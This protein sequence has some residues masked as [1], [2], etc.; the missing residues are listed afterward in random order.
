MT[1]SNKNNIPYL[2]KKERAFKLMVDGKPFISLAGEVHNSSSSSLKYMDEHVWERLVYFNCNTAVVPV[3]W[4]LIEPIEGQFDFTLVDGLI[5]GARRHNLKLVL[6]WFGMWKNSHSTYVPGWVKRDQTRFPR[7]QSSGG[8]KL[9]IV[10]CHS[11]EALQSDSNAF[12][13]L[14]KHIADVDHT[15]RTVIMMQVEN[16]V[17]FLGTDRDYSPHANAL[18]E[19]DVPDELIEYLKQHSNQLSPELKKQ[20]N[21]ELTVSSSWKEHFGKSAGVIF[22]SWHM[23]RFLDQVTAAGKAEYNLPMFVNVWL[24]QY[25]EQE[26]GQYPSGGPIQ[27]MID[28]WKAGGPHIDIIAPDIY[29]NE[30][31]EVCEVY[32]RPDNALFIPETRRDK[33]TAANVFYAVGEHNALGYTPF[34]IETM[35]NGIDPF[36]AGFLPPTHFMVMDSVGIGPLLS[37]SFELIHHMT[38]LISKYAGTG[39]M[40]GVLQDKAYPSAIRLGAYRLPIR[41]KNR[42]HSEDAP[43]GGL[44]IAVSDFEF[45]IVG[46]SFSVEFI[47]LDPAGV[48]TD[49]LSIDEGSFRDGMWIPGRRLNGDEYRVSLGSEP[50][51]LKVSLYNY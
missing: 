14:M 27:D 49:F 44:I 29:L 18:F 39:K 48:R 28:I 9:P 51:A 50:Q 47:S 2:E 31:A 38:P 45:I 24:K 15:D 19:H 22:T 46:H 40:R 23:A 4:E 35:D 25:E 43:A 13:A 32:A 20:W 33:V 10:S 34:G 37:K 6:I 30:F 12:R 11:N 5:E 26:P 36:G 7:V 41:F 16:E 8:G 17:G 42:I 21:A 1:T 3:S